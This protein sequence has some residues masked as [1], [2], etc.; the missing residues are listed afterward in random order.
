[1]HA[2][3]LIRH[4]STLSGSHAPVPEV[5]GRSCNHIL[6]TFRMLPILFPYRLLPWLHA[7]PYRDRVSLQLL[8]SSPDSFRK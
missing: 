3:A 2:S 8:S 7:V 6:S 5:L 4:G 1:M